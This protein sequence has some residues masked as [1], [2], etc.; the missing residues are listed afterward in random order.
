MLYKSPNVLLLYPTE[1]QQLNDI[2][3]DLS[4]HNLLHNQ[5]NLQKLED[6][7]SKLDISNSSFITIDSVR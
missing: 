6:E 7:L 2:M 3:S 1:V 5:V 4:K